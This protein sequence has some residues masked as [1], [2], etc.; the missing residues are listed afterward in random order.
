MADRPGVDRRWVVRGAGINDLD[1]RGAG[2]LGFPHLAHHKALSVNDLL[3]V[4]KLVLGTVAGVGALAA[5]V[6]NYRKQRLAEVAEVRERRRA[7]DDRVRV[8]NERFATAAAQL[9]HD[10]PAVR[11]AGVHAMVGLADDWKH[12]RQTC[13]DVLCAYLQ[14]PYEA[15]PGPDASTAERLA[16]GRSQ[17]VRHTVIA[18]ITAHLQPEASTS[19]QGCIFDFT[20]VRFDGG[21]FSGAVFIGGRVPGVD[22]QPQHRPELCDWGRQDRR[23]A[24]RGPSAGSRGG[25]EVGGPSRCCGAARRSTPGTRAAPRWVERALLQ[26][27]PSRPGMWSGPRTR[28]SP[29]APT[30]YPAP[31]GRCTWAA[32]TVPVLLTVEWNVTS[33]T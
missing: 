6:M 26:A 16:F 31:T 18:V 32:R 10:E 29:A 23:A 27:P 24:R 13:I 15:D 12:G 25:R 30:W 28:R 4:L 8:F 9:G 19:W 11:L 33:E 20:G 2:G 7:D 14:M 21:S 3:E 1:G 22:R 17:K 5:L